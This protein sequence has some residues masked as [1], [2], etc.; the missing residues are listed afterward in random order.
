MVSEDP[1]RSF[2]LSEWVLGKFRK[3]QDVSIGPGSSQQASED[4]IGLQSL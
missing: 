2:V 4:F 3:V 1:R